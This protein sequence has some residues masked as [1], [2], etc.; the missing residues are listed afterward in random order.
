MDLDFDLDLLR[1]LGDD[2]R[3]AGPDDAFQFLVLACTPRLLPHAPGGVERGQ[4]HLQLVE[5]KDTD[6][7]QPL[8]RRRRLLVLTTCLAQDRVGLA[9]GLGTDTETLKQRF[10]NLRPARARGGLPGALLA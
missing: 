8:C 3:K 1:R 4:R 2:A 10:Q 7:E 5:A 6:I 9:A